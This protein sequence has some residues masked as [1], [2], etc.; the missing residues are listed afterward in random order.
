[1]CNVFAE[2]NLQIDFTACGTAIQFD[3]I[4][5][6]GMK[7]VD[8]IAE[9]GDTLFFVEIKDFQ[10]PNAPEERRNEDYEMLVEAGT[11]KKSVFNLEMGE[12]I[13]DS[14]LRRYAE[15]GS[16]TKRVVYLLL[17]NLDGL[18]E[19]ARG[20]LKERISGHIPTGLNHERFGAF[21]HISFDLVNSQQLTQYG[22]VVR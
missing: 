15:G 7:A 8:F 14:L 16:F 11:A 22:I 10:N 13:K 19:V 21:T 6:Y 9:T 4:N 2:G 1:V 18:D 17:I 20:R 3:E 5:T 12:K